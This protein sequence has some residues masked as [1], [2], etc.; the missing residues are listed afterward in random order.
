[1]KDYNTHS[2]P[3]CTAPQAT[4]TNPELRAH[5]RN[6]RLGIIVLITSIVNNIQCSEN[7]S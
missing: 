6:Q 5:Q 2:A 7:T 3:H 4:P 1:M